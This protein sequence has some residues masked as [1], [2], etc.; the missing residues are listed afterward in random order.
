[1]GLMW[2]WVQTWEVL[3]MC[4]IISWEHPWEVMPDLCF[5][6]GPEEFEKEEQVAAEKAATKEEF[7]SEWTA[8]FTH[9][10]IC[11]LSSLLL[12]LGA[13]LVQRHAGTQFSGSPLKTGMLS[14][15]LHPGL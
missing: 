1:M 14:L 13:E 15:P 7:Q 8:W 9:Q 10:F 2:W 11:S 5:Y 3:C 4:G 12:K 6:R